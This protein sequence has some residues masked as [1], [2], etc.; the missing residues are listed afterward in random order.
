MGLWTQALG[1]M[2]E[3]NPECDALGRLRGKDRCLLQRQ[4][5]TEK[6]LEGDGH[7]DKP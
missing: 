2:E 5:C 1:D 4:R 6:T 7:S 3:G